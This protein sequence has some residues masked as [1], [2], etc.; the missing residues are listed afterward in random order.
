MK[1]RKQLMPATKMNV[2]RAD[3]F[4]DI[5][6]WHRKGTAR[7]SPRMLIKCGDCDNA[8]TIYHDE[9]ALEIGGVHGSLANWRE[10]LLPLLTPK[11]GAGN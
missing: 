9:E 5:R 6:V 8:V 10:I 7:H 1:T 4:S 3:G 2:R 11:A